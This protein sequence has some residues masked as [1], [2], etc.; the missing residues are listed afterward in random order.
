M[1]YVSCTSENNSEHLIS[2]SILD[3][4]DS[5]LSKEQA[6]LPIMEHIVWTLANMVG[7][8]NNEVRQQVL[9]SSVFSR[10]LKLSPQEGL[11]SKVALSLAWLFSNSLKW[12]AEQKGSFEDSSL[13]VNH[14]CDFFLRYETADITFEALWGICYFLSPVEERLQRVNLLLGLKVFDRLLKYL[15]TKKSSIVTPLLTIMSIVPEADCHGLASIRELWVV[16][17]GFGEPDCFKLLQ[18]NSKGQQR[19]Y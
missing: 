9:R 19:W 2:L 4:M 5:L 15:E 11:D 12:L 18:A 6:S 7:E 17:V 16:D 14:L 10:L 1:N 8:P 3:R 13:L